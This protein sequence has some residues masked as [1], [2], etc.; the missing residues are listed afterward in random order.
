[1]K[2]PETKLN[3]G[4]SLWAMSDNEPIEYKVCKI[5]CRINSSDTS[6]SYEVE[7]FRRYKYEGVIRHSNSISEHEIGQ[8]FFLS[9]KELLLHIF[10]DCLTE[11]I[12]VK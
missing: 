4:D 6:I 1:M 5:T 8:R 7:W 3:L 11:G 10:G 9:K 12:V 2:L